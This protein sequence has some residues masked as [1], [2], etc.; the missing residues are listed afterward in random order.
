MHRERSSSG[1]LPLARPMTEFLIEELGDEVLV[2][3]QTAHRAH[4]LSSAAA[5]LWRLCDGKRSTAEA[6][7]LLATQG[8]GDSVAAVLGQL[9]TAGLLRARKR[10]A[11]RVDTGRR[12][13]LGKTAVAAG[14]VLASPAI[15]S[16]VAPSVAE[17][18]SCGTKGLPCCSPPGLCV[19]G[20]KNCIGNV[21]IK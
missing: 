2:Y 19:S 5:K 6:E 15:F 12:A 17:A 4:C 18:A 20:N 14:I 13:M 16:I 3:D 1:A 11:R 8:A 9:E 7:R 10:E 21:C